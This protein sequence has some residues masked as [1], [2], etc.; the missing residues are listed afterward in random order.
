MGPVSTRAWYVRDMHRTHT[1]WCTPV[2]TCRHS[3]QQTCRQREEK[4]NQEADRDSSFYSDIC[5]V[6]ETDGE[7]IRPPGASATLRLPCHPS[8]PPL[9]LHPGT[10]DRWHLA[11]VTPLLPWKNKLCIHYIKSMGHLTTNM[12]PVQPNFTSFSLP[13]ITTNGSEARDEILNQ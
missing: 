5:S 3:Q 10:H 9:N 12:N 13:K 4:V 11:N 2:Y 8:V 6:P 7:P 1:K